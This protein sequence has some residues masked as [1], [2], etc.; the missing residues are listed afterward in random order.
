[1]NAAPTS[2]NLVHL[3]IVLAVTFVLLGVPYFIPTIIAYSRKKANRL[4]I[5]A[6]NALLGWTIVGWVVA[7]VW[8]LKIDV[9][10]RPT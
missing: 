7:L 6:L 1:M 9:V 4:A 8:A 10:D 2:V 3:L 5:L